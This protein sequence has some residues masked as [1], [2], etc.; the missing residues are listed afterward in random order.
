MAIQVGWYFIST[1]PAKEPDTEVSRRRARAIRWL[2]ATGMRLA[3]MVGARCADLERVDYRTAAGTPAVGWLLTV[4][5]KGQKLREVPIPVHLVEEL[6]H[7][8]AVAGKK[9]D[10]LPRTAREL[11]S[12]PSLTVRGRR[13][14]G[15][16]PGCT[17]RFEHS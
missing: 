5:G 6:G 8:L 3:E 1:Q 15:L 2:Y 17:S 9:S 14:H 11:A 16:P 12:W 7:E 10:V 13:T 4:I